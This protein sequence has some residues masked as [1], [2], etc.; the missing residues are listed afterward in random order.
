MK[1]TQPKLELL[2]EKGLI[3]DYEIINV[4]EEGNPGKK[5]H[6]RNTER[7]TLVFPDETVFQIDMICSGS[8]Q[9][10]FFVF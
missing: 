9:D 4:D 7:L 1:V 3:K 8:L 10:T 5:S 2:V 6:G